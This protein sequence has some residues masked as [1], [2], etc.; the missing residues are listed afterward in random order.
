MSI[1][2]PKETLPLRSLSGPFNHKITMGNLANVKTT[3]S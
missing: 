1:Y 2:Y 3:L